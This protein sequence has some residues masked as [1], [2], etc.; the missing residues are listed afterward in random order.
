MR[1]RATRSALA[2]V[3][4]LLLAGC[5][6]SVT[7]HVT[8]T[9]PNA[10]I[11]PTLT[12]ISTVQ[13]TPT[14]TPTLE[15]TATEQQWIPLASQS[16]SDIIAAAKQSTIFQDNATGEGDSVSVS[17]LGTPVY[18]LGLSTSYSAALPAYYDIPLLSGD[19][20]VIGCI[21]CELNST[22]TAIYVGFIA[23]YGQPRTS[24]SV[25]QITAQQALAEVSALH[26][27]SPKAGTQPRLIYF[28]FNQNAEDTGRIN[29][30]GGGNSPED[31][32][33]EFVGA[34]GNQ[35]FAGNDGHAYWNELPRAPSIG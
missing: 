31:P 23:Q 22:A 8:S 4:V 19:S 35:H 12:P 11:T 26:H 24:G 29:W 13:N 2:A 14:R 17:R 9:P 25:A 6:S 20:T 10:T 33:W 1:H 18:V 5:S 21:M 15:P 28:P 32:M 16:P 3:A 30:K 7:T 34:D 27:V